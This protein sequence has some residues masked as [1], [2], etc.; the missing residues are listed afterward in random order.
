MCKNVTKIINWAEVKGR[1]GEG[2]E[3]EEG[4]DNPDEVCKI[5]VVEMPSNSA[6]C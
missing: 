3:L 1:N 5:V 6:S 4:M 2:I